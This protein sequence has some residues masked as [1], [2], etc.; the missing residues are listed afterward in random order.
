MKNTR[1]IG[2]KVLETPIPKAQR[3]DVTI[4]QIHKDGQLTD[5]G[6]AFEEATDLM[7]RNV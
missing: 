4:S 5:E 6:T 1:F 3:L 7:K 2:L